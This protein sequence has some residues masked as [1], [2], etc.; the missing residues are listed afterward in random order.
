MYFYFILI[1]IRLLFK[2][3]YYLLFYLKIYS[4]YIYIY[5]VYFFL[6][7]FS[8]LNNRCFMYYDEILNN[9]FVIIYFF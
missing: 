8:I 1:L 2:N 9:D 5:E 7:Y 4:I 3:Q 6:N